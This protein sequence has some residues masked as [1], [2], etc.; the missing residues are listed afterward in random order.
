MRAPDVPNRSPDDVDYAA[1]YST[2][3]LWAVLL[4]VFLP[5]PVRAV[6]IGP[7]V[8][9]L[10]VA[11]AVGA[12]IALLGVIRRDNLVLEHLGLCLL[13]VGPTAYAAV[14]L[15]LGVLYVMHG[16]TERIGTV[17]YALVPALFFNKRR[18]FL[19]RRARLLANGEERP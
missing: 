8:T 9:L 13:I 4:I 6:I 12:A 19:A 1:I 10:G 5:A 3:L 16:N 11:V 17:V 15:V 18:R 7:V 2:T 14:Q